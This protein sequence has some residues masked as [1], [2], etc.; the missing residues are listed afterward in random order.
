MSAVSISR[1]NT[2]APMTKMHTVAS[3]LSV[4]LM[5]CFET[6]ALPAGAMPDW[7]IHT[8]SGS[9][10]IDSQQLLSTSM[11]AQGAKLHCRGSAHPSRQPASQQRGIHA[12]VW[13]LEPLPGPVQ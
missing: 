5:L 3:A 8:E 4:L 1:C 13:K 6:L 9:V 7:W 12:A 11:L 10:G 2:S